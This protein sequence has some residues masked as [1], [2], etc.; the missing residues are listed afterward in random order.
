MGL[1][2]GRACLQLILIHVSDQILLLA[3]VFRIKANNDVTPVKL[4]VDDEQDSRHYDEY[5]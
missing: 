1:C 4:D 5:R 2:W 3:L